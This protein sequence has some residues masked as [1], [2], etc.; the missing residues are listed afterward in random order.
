VYHYVVAQFSFMTVQVADVHAHVQGLV[1]VLKMANWLKSILLKN[2]V[3]LCI[4]W[5]AKRLNAK[6]LSCLQ[7][8][9]SVA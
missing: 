4:F 2:S 8:D 7:W 1:S 5:W 9:V 6:D 3:L